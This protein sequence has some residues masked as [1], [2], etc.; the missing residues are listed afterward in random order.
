MNQFKFVQSIQ[1]GEILYLN[2]TSHSEP[3]LEVAI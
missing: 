1:V 2:I 3:G